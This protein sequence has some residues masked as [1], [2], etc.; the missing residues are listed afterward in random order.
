MSTLAFNPTRSA[1][2][3]DFTQQR[4]AELENRLRSYESILEQCYTIRWHDVK[5]TAEMR[6]NEDG[7]SSW[8]IPLPDD[9]KECDCFRLIKKLG[10]DTD[11]YTYYS[12]NVET[13]HR[14]GGSYTLTDKD[15]EIGTEVYIGLFVSLKSAVICTRETHKNN[16]IPQS[17]KGLDRAINMAI[18]DAGCTPPIKNRRGRP[19]KGQ[20]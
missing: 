4:L 8:K 19:R 17:S 3:V 5:L 9:L 11:D 15:L 6:V 10:I 14:E 2:E 7:G 1:D 13:F 20:K 18:V 12:S 16:V